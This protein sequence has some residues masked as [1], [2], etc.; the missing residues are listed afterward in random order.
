MAIHPSAIVDKR[1]EIDS[2]AEIGAFCIIGPHVSIAAG[3]VLHAHVVVENHTRIGS[4]TVVHPF[5]RLGGTPQDLKFKGEEARLIIG[6]HNVIREGVTMNI[7]TAGGH[8]ETRV[9]SHCLFMAQSH[10]AHD[11]RVGD[12]VIMANGVALAGH[13]ELADNVIVGGLAAVHQFCRIGRRA[14]I[15]GGAMVAQDIPPFVIAQGDRAQV[16][17]LNLVGLRR[18]GFSRD[19]ITQIRLAY[20]LLFYPETTRQ[21]ALAYVESHLAPQSAEVAEMCAFIRASARGVAQGRRSA[22]EGDAAIEA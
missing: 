14:F 5:V 16:A 3:C 8:M 9:G 4:G 20:R 7:G 2:S 17:G 1:A 22:N 18:S 19:Q 10:I 6:E 13:V 21:A 11:C 15:G 12:G